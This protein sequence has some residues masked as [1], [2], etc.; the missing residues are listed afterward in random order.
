MLYLTQNLNNEQFPVN[1]EQITVTSLKNKFN[2]QFSSSKMKPD[3]NKVAEAQS[4]NVKFSCFLESL[5]G[6]G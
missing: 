4:E 2:F 5:T 3:L 6:S 1:R